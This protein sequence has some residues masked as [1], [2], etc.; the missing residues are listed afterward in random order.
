LADAD[1]VLTAE[2]VI[3]LIKR[4]TDENWFN[5]MMDQPDGKAIIMMAAA[6]G[7]A[8]S[9]CLDA[10]VAACKISEA[11]TGSQ[12]VC[13]LVIHRAS[14]TATG[15]IRQGFKFVT[16]IGVELAV[17]TTV[18]VSA[19]Q[20][21]VTLPLQTLR[22]ID[23]VNKR[24]SAFDDTLAAGDY[25][26]DIISPESI[27]VTNDTGGPLLGIGANVFAYVS[28]SSIVGATMDWLS[29]HGNERGCRRQPGEDGEAYRERVRQIPD[30]VTPVAI[31]EAVHGAQSKA[32]LPTVYMV[33]PYRD[34]ASDAARANLSLLFA[35]GPAFD[36]GFFDDPF[37]KN[38]AGKLP[39]RTH[40][41]PDLRAGRAYF[42]ESIVGP[43]VE[44]NGLVMYAGAS[45]FDDPAWGYPDVG[46]HP[47]LTGG[48]R[49]IVDEARIKRAGGVQFDVTL[50][51]AK[52]LNSPASVTVTRYYLTAATDTGEY[53][54]LLLGTTNPTDEAHAIDLTN[55]TE[56]L[57]FAS[58]SGSPGMA[59]WPSGVLHA[60]I[61]I[62]MRN[63]QVGRT[64]K[65]YTGNGDLVYTDMVWDWTHGD[66][67]QV[68]ESAPV[69]PSITETFATL[70][71]DIP[72]TTLSAGP[73]GRLGLNLR[74]RVYVGDEEST[75]DGEDIVVRV[76]GDNASYID[77]LFTVGTGWTLT[78]ATGKAWLIRQ[79]L[80]TC[81]VYKT[82]AIVSP[83][84][85]FKVLITLE[86]TSV[87]DS[88]WI[89][90]RAGLPLRQKELE[91]MGYFSQW[92]TKIEAQVSSSIGHTL[93]LIGTFWVTER[94]DP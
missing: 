64:Y 3:A 32:E 70:E 88:G 22:Q 42:R 93:N 8:L 9:E 77:T 14:T 73:T 71:F 1:I 31:Q 18:A 91:A 78:A 56:W 7:A 19:G 34:Q 74:M 21:T 25:L 89:T 87:L 30:A 26:D 66:V 33:E 16:S 38:L 63:P 83:G 49:S 53:T 80:V 51:N 54:G 27:A 75:F 59:V 94:T 50:E 37:G 13:T 23:L 5:A 86:D 47:Y 92:V 44:P 76:G 61:H 57:V 58:P 36:E 41:L 39:L 4:T 2:Q 45:Y 48:L 35:D 15:T 85:A 81:D 6:M 69:Q 72:V 65:L 12:G 67:Y 79:G 20:A 28:S 24:E 52:I 62:K 82:S 55:G 10:Q 17:S 43:L 46:M 68:R 60:H 40:E 29:E 90:D 84:D 11:P